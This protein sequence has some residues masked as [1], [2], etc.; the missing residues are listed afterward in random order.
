[1]RFTKWA[2]SWDFGTLSHIM[3]LCKV[4]M[5]TYMCVAMIC[6]W[7]VSWAASPNLSDITTLTFITGPVK[8]NFEC[9]NIFFPLSISLNMCF[10]FSKEPSHWDGS[11][12][13]L[14]HMFW[15]RNKKINCLI[16][17]S[18]LGACSIYYIAVFCQRG[19]VSTS[20]T[21]ISK[22]VRPGQER[23]YQS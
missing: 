10:G 16:T 17:H 23:S 20:S 21:S 15:L 9:K 22:I 4:I 18:Y 11:F 7:P 19:S 14:Q 5:L 13:L 8:H 6:F 12:E 2:S 1:M 3:T